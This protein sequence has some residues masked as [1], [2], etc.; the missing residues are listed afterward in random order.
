MLVNNADNYRQEVDVAQ[1]EDY[2]LPRLSAHG[3]EGVYWPKSRARTMSD[4][5][6][7][8]VDGCATFY[9]SAK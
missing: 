9:R 4:T 7:R 1:Y 8:K 5:E 6:R 2:F 3:Y